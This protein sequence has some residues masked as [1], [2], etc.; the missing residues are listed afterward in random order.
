MNQRWRKLIAKFAS[1]YILL[2]LTLYFQQQRLFF[3]PSR[4]LKQTPSSYQLDYQDVWVWIPIANTKQQTERLHGW[5][6]RAKNPDAPVLFY[7]HHNAINISANITQALQFQ[8]LGYSVFLFDY[9]GFGRSEGSFPTESQVYEDAGAAW[10]YLTQERQIVPNKIIIYG[11]SI[12]GAVAID[13][14]S[15]HPEAA[16][17]IV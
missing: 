10:N 11:H 5:W 3:F 17:L 4:E 7:F 14:A 9:R 6:I 8:E 2:C 12:G 15:K 13:L 16:A 1:A